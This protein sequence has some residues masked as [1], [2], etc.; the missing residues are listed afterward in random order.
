MKIERMNKGEW[1]KIKAFFDLRTDEGFVI[2]GFKLIHGING[3]FV[4]NPSQKGNDGEY[5]DTIFAEKELKDE[6]S[7]IAIDHYGQEV[8]PENEPFSD[9]SGQSNSFEQSPP[10]SKE[11]S[12]E[13][14]SFT[15]DDIPF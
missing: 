6:L 7:Q 11:E 1:G 5:Y 2:K 13:T 15:D 12:S 9:T 10:S 14:P 8:M 4:G 3:L